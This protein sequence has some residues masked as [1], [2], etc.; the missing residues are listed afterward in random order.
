MFGHFRAPV[1]GASRRRLVA[2]AVT[3]AVV[4]SV[5]GVVSAPQ[6]LADDEYVPSVTLTHAT[7]G[8]L[9][10]ATPR[11][12]HV[13][14]AGDAPV[15]GWHDR[16]G[17][18]LSRSYFT[19]DVARFGGKR[20]VSATLAGRE[21]HA[22]DCAKRSIELWSTAPFTAQSSWR[23]PPAE[24]TKVATSGLPSSGCLVENA[25]FDVAQALR[26]AV[27]AG[28]SKLTL[29]LRVPAR[30]EWDKRFGRTFANDLKLQVSYN[31]APL[32]P[33]ELLLGSGQ[34][35]P[36]ATQAPGTYLYHPGTQ[37]GGVFAQDPDGIDEQLQGR[38]AVWPVDDPVKR[39]E[40]V[41]TVYPHWGFNSFYLDSLNIELEHNRTYGWALQSDDGTDV[42]PWTATCYFT[43]DTVSPDHPPTITSPEYPNSTA[44]T[45]DVG[46]P[47]HFTFD[48]NGVAD[49]VGF[50][51]GRYS[52][53]TYVAADHLGG[54]ATIEFTP[55]ES[56]EQYLQVYSVDRAGRSSAT[57]YHRFRVRESRPD[58]NSTDYLWY[59]TW[60]GIGV[61]GK[62]D[63][64]PKV[65]N[66]VQ[67]L[68]QLNDDPEQSVAAGADGKASVT[69]TPSRGGENSLKVRTKDSA[70]AVGAVRDYR[71]QVATAPAV[72][73]QSSLMVG[74]ENTVSLAPGMPDVVEYEY[75][76]GDDDN[77][78]HTTLAADAA[79]K[80]SFAWTPSMDNYPFDL[81]VSSRSANGQT[82][83]VRE[84]SPSVDLARPTI[85]RSGGERPGSPAVFTL[86]SRM[87][88][89]TEWFWRVEGGNEEGSVP[90]RPDGTGTFSWTPKDDGSPTISFWAKNSAGATSAGDF[91]SWTV[92]SSPRITSTDYPEWSWAGG[93]GVAGQFTFR[94]SENVS[95]VTE[96]V[97]AYDN[98]RD[99]GPEQT[100]Q[101]G[102][103]GSA[104]V[105]ITPT[106]GG[107]KYLRVRSKSADG[108]R[109]GQ[110][111]YTFVVNY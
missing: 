26:A 59:G 9:D 74:K 81:R 94:P 58:V 53:D 39:E 72:T 106:E 30:S 14:P 66:A 83:A 45:G 76:F 5:L 79:H 16:T 35:Y 86:S 29:E 102:P 67:Y 50:Y 70:G 8:Y 52:P 78:P 23:N 101:A 1:S 7:W 18:H 22:N 43:L 105:T 88:N 44:P 75:W 110:G 4:A 15:G 40:R 21:T 33:T 95:D 98:G 24:R 19:F 51:Y 100:V 104:T 36:C 103:D 47:G 71:F 3:S 80:A 62:F 57:E 34:G 20:I 90:A 41:T 93:I 97:Y 89:V 99:P 61:P 10:K 85:S 32:A 82:S 17:Q 6:A 92:W 49:V 109:S 65:P 108:S 48:A 13:D 69:I 107:Y 63:F 73:L 27:A 56:G 96:Y 38:L 12:A 68:Y 2:Y 42:S 111:S 77:A 55:T 84:V 87:P 31:T 25:T 91:E 54:S 28:E 64:A 11:Q 46:T 60:G 37:V